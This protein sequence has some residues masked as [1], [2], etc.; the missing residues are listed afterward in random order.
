M[1]TAVPMYLLSKTLIV[2][3]GTLLVCHS[4]RF[5]IEYLFLF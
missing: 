4:I 5:R 1:G 2:Y 3:V